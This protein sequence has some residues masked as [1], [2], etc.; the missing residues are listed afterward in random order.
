MTRDPQHPVKSLPTE[1]R[2]QI[3]SEQMRRFVRSLPPFAVKPDVPA[4]LR[5]LLDELNRAEKKTRARD[6]NSNGRS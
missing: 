6:R 1:V 2:R 3:G 4:H 5:D